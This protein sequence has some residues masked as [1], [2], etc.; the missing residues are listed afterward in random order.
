VRRDLRSWKSRSLSSKVSTL[1]FK[2]LSKLTSSSRI[3]MP[4]GIR[5]TLIVP[6]SGRKSCEGSSV[7]T[8]H[9]M[10]YNER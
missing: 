1:K 5:N 7:V 6:V 3:P 10:S 4:A 8:R 9:Y 2:T